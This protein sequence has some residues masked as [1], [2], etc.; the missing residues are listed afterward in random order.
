MTERCGVDDVL[1]TP[2]ESSC[3][4]V[5]G[6][7]SLPDQH[8]AAVFHTLLGKI[9]DAVPSRPQFNSG[10][11]SADFCFLVFFFP[12]LGRVALWA[13]SGTVAPSEPVGGMR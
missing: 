5:K 9:E 13:L 4:G 6:V 10:I 11:G 8:L 12:L 7:A 1:L 2:L 3:W